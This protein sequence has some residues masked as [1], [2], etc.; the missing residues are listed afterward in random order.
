MAIRAKLTKAVLTLSG[1]VLLSACLAQTPTLKPQTRPAGLTQSAKPETPQGPSAESLALSR[2]YTR[3]QNDLLAQGLMRT[4]GGGPDTRYGPDDL[5]RNFERIAFI[6]EHPLDSVGP[7]DGSISDLHRW[8]KPVRMRIEFGDTVSAEDR[9]TDTDFISSYA[10]R[11]RRITGHP[12]GITRSTSANFHVLVMSADDRDQMLTRVRQIMPGASS[13]TLAVFRN[14][15]RPTYCLVVAEPGG[16]TGSEY[17]TAIA[18]IR[19]EHPPLLRRSC[20]HE[21][22]AQGL[23][24]T[25]DS[26]RA[27]PSIFNDDEEFAYLT[28]HDEMLLKML[29]DKRLQPGM[30]LDEARPIAAQIAR[31]LTA[32][33]F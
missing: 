30:S 2:Y 25:N 15:S 32:T 24:L 11:L 29:Y 17:K 19:A 22:L 7:A 9:A 18:L 10:A 26:P 14:L 23:G 6:N 1:S 31:E 21:E 16:R 27:R 4:D 13:G 33:N 8:Q 20:I 12:I 5:L 28:T 3:V